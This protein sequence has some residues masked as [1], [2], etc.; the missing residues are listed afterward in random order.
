[1]WSSLGRYPP[2]VVQAG[3]ALVARDAELAELTT[4]W[5]TA[6]SGTG[7]VAVVSGEAGVGKTRLVTEL[8]RSVRAQG[9]VLRGEAVPLA[10]D[11][12][13][14]P[15]FLQLLRA[16]RRSLGA[17][18]EHLPLD[19]S[20][21]SI[22]SVI[23]VF[24][25]ALDDLTARQPVLVVVEDLHWTTPDSCAVLSVLA[26]LVGEQRAMLVMTC[27]SADLAPTHHA[28]R[29]VA[30][31]ARTGLAREVSLA[32]FG[33]A[34]VADQIEALTGT[35]PESSVL[36]DVYER[37]ER[38]RTPRRGGRPHRCARPTRRDPDGSTSWWWPASSSSASTAEASPRRWRSPGRPSS[39]SCSPTT[40]AGTAGGSR[41]PCAR[42]S[43]P[44]C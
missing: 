28:R 44:R 17:A 9:I 11:S 10:A 21:R 43:T 32:R 8:E 6:A 25:G 16:A 5:E 33:V 35:N 42:R 1:M 2:V 14:F 3:T 22:D 18:G 20:E 4:S 27:R 34:A 37:S 38:Q 7:T 40:P 30:E 31:L 13:G 12:L 41:R 23:D 39:S 36:A 26:R 29:L 19:L 24:I 15:P